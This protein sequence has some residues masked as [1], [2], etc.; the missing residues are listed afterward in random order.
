[1]FELFNELTYFY[2]FA[3]FHFSLVIKV[4]LIYYVA[5]YLPLLTLKLL[6]SISIDFLM[7]KLLDAKIQTSKFYYLLRCLLSK[8]L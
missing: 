4:P 7:Q 2:Q 3:Q 6:V 1:M 5:F 8:L